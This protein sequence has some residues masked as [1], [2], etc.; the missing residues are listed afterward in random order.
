MQGGIPSILWS[1]GTLFLGVMALGTSL[2]GFLF[3]PLT[4]PIRILLSGSAILLIVPER[5]TDL[6]GA[7]LLAGVLYKEFLFK[8]SENILKDT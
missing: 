8:R 5:S 6:A 7:I 1:S 2:V 4:L 3:K